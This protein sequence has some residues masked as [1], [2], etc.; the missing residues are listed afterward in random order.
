MRYLRTVSKSNNICAQYTIFSSGFIQPLFGPS[1][2]KIN[3]SA[4]S[5]YRYNLASTF[6]F[7]TSF[8]RILGLPDS[9]SSIAAFLNLGAVNL[10]IPL[11][12]S[13]RYNYTPMQKDNLLFTLKIK[14][15]LH[16]QIYEKALSLCYKVQGA[17][18]Q[19]VQ[20]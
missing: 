10:Q 11:V 4:T 15:L 18:K 7:T 8:R 14:K 16:N 20:F 9:L 12:A 19:T 5:F 2:L 3:S 17:A 6:F 1:R 13:V